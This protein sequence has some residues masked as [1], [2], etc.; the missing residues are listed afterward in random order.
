M[1]ETF[2]NRLSKRQTSS[3]SKTFSQ[4]HT[5]SLLRLASSM[6]SP[7][8]MNLIELI[9]KSIIMKARLL[10]NKIKMYQFLVWKCPGS[11]W[12]RPTCWK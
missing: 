12:P 1:Q 3:N 6:I 10:F 11:S 9:Q 7:H 2:N 5:K 4:C 8:P